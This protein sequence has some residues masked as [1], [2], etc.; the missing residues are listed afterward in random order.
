MADTASGI[1]CDL[2]VAFE[3]NVNDGKI[4]VMKYV[5][6][7]GVKGIENS[8]DNL[9]LYP[10]PNQG[11]F[12]I[13]GALNQQDKEVSIEVVDM[14]GRDVYRETVSV[15]DGIVDVPLH[16]NNILANSTFIVKVYSASVSKTFNIVVE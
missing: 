6:N 4:T 13:Q 11:A 15:Q 2:Y 10:N 8:T 5:T 12:T 9:S 7:T 1:W 16:L 3:D 14:L